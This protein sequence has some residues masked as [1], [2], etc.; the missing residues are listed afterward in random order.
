MRDGKARREGAVG[1]AAGES[2]GDHAPADG[3]DAARQVYPVRVAREPGRLLVGTSRGEIQV[4]DTRSGEA[5]ELAR[6]Q[7]PS[8]SADGRWLTYVEQSEEADVWMAASP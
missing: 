7:S 1:A 6:G 5:R 8:L 2:G 4:V 3:F